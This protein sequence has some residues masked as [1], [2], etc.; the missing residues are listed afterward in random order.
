MKAY[1]QPPEAYKA[2]GTEIKF[3][4]S[5]TIHFCLPIIKFQVLVEEKIIELALK[6]IKS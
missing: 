3:F 6:L 4:N 2:L 5:E 1:S